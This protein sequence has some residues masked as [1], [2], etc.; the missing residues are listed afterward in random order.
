[1]NSQF[2]AAR[3]GEERLANAI[4]VS[5]LFRWRGDG[6]PDETEEAVAAHRTLVEILRADRW[7]VAPGDAGDRP[8]YA[9]R[10][11]RPTA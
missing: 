4:E 3:S 11:R 6:P 2:Y 1:V 5:S 10:L 7:E 8:W 9:L